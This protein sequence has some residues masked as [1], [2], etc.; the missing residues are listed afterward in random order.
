[1]PSMPMSPCRA[2]LD[3]PKVRLFASFAG[4]VPQCPLDESAWRFALH[5]LAALRALMAAN[6]RLLLRAWPSDRGAPVPL[7]AVMDLLANAYNAET[8]TSLPVRR[9]HC[10]SWW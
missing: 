6:W 2:H 9:W 10:F 3:D 4:L 5:L 8:P 1:M 7:P